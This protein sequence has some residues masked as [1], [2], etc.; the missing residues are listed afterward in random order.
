R[1]PAVVQEGNQSQIPERLARDRA[2]RAAGGR[3]GADIHRSIDEIILYAGPDD[4]LKTEHVVRAH[5]QTGA[6][7]HAPAGRATR[8]VEG[9]VRQHI[10]PP[11]PPYHRAE[12]PISVLA[13][14]PIFSRDIRHGI[15]WRD[16]L[17]LD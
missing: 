8:E 15:T 9:V 1:R 13:A 7:R 17:Q 4:G 10:V 16:V 12:L 2:R 11:D 3:L 14:E 5:V 6:Q